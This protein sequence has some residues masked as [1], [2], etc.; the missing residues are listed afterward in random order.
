M[1]AI[2]HTVVNVKTL[3]SF[4]ES[5]VRLHGEQMGH[6]LRLL[7][8]FYQLLQVIIKW[9]TLMTKE[10][11]RFKKGNG[12]RESI[13]TEMQNRNRPVELINT[14]LKTELLTVTHAFPHCLINILYVMCRYL[15]SLSSLIWMTIMV[16]W[17][18]WDT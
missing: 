3:D 6:V 18:Y 15:S 7:R 9:K 8:C 11:E 12:E 17:E 13:R 10:S 16:W 4:L 14:K 1:K 2:Y 5:F